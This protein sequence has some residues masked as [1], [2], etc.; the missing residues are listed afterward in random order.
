MPRFWVVEFFLSVF[1]GWA[2]LDR[3]YAGTYTM[4]FIKLGVIWGLGGIAAGANYLLENKDMGFGAVAIMWLP[5]V[6]GVSAGLVWAGD[7]IVSFLGEHDDEYPELAG[8]SIP[9]KIL[10]LVGIIG[11]GG[12]LISAILETIAETAGK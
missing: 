2:A 4:A 6:F 8:P 10:M 1:F 9:I 11:G 12:I 3:F 5:V 7:A